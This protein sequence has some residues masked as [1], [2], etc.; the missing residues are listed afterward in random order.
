MDSL[1]SWL[2]MFKKHFPLR[3]LHGIHEHIKGSQKSC[4]NLICLT[5]TQYFSTSFEHA[6]L[7]CECRKRYGLNPKGPGYWG[8]VPAIPH[9]PFSLFPDKR[10]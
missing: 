5:L 6:V 4:S 10:T 9:V 2:T 8:H 3:P 7:L 1:V